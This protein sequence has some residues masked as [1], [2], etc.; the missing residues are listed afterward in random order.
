MVIIYNYLILSLIIFICVCH[1]S[2]TEQ[3][4]YDSDITFCK[5]SAFFTHANIICLPLLE[6]FQVFELLQIHIGLKGCGSSSSLLE[7]PGTAHNRLYPVG[8]DIIA[9]PLPRTSKLGVMF[10]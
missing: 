8:L 2:I 6:Y 9:A 5:S 10:G 3:A 7:S 1:H 4:L